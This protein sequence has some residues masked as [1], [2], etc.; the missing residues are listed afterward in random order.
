MLNESAKWDKSILSIQIKSNFASLTQKAGPFDMTVFFAKLLVTVFVFLV[1][2]S[3]Y[4]KW[5]WP[6]KTF[7]YK[8]QWRDQKNEVY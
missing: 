2:K 6:S 3:V 5:D 1:M 4:H 7:S 8:R